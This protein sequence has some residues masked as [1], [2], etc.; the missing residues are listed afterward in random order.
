MKKE[1]C[2]KWYQSIGL[3]LSYSRWNY[4]KKSV[5]IPSCET[6]R[7]SQ[8]SLFLLFKGEY[9]KGTRVKKGVK[10][11]QARARL[12][13]EGIRKTER[14]R[15]KSQFGKERKIKREIEIQYNMKNGN[16]RRK[17][18]GDSKRRK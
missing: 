16:K 15:T 18:E 17:R 13:E 2:W 12:R 6:S 10:W 9:G 4:Q 5:Q 1:G 11:T 8:R 3:A 14:E 7:I